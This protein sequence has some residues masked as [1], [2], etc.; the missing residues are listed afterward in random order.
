MDLSVQQFRTKAEQ[1]YLDMFEAAGSAFPGARAPFVSNLRAKAIE[2]Y[3]KQG[4]PHRRIEAWKYT[5]LRARLVDV[6][7]LMKADGAAVGEAALS[8]ALGAE[9]ASLPAYR[10]VLV[11]GDL[12][13][14]LPIS[15]ALKRPVSRRSLSR[16][17]EATVRLKRPCRVNRAMT[18]CLPSTRR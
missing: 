13:A 15:P 14:D 3:A 4:L 10:L 7:P 8:Q 1:A 6:N 11:E 12:R 5:D 17:G 9:L 18:T 2:A 16:P